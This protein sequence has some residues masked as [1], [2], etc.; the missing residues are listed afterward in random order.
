MCDV[1]AVSTRVQHETTQ[2]LYLC[3]AENESNM[4]ALSIIMLWLKQIQHART[5]QK[6]IRIDYES[7][8]LR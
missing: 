7:H 6:Q 5:G 4:H 2:T 1:V 3:E 8:W